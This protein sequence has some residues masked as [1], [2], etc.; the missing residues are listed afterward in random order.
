MFLCVYADDTL[1]EVTDSIQYNCITD[2][3]ELLAMGEVAPMALDDSKQVSTRIGYDLMI[4]L[5]QLE[6]QW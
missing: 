2:V 1:P 5:E 6:A 3:N 4:L